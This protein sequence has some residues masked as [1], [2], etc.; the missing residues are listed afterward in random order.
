MRYKLTEG[1]ESRV[2]ELLRLIR[3]TRSSL[4]MAGAAVHTEWDRIRWRF[5]SEDDARQ[6]YTSL[7]EFEIEEVRS[8]VQRFHAQV[9][10]GAA[11]AAAHVAQV[12]SSDWQMQS[13]A[14]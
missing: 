5:P 11:Q 2:R 9:G 7:S 12:S 8:K 1:T 3:E 13:I 6:G 14:S 4:A 10:A